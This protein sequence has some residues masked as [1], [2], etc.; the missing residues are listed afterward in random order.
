MEGINQCY[1]IKLILTLAV[2]GLLMSGCNT[3]NY[4][5]SND[6]KVLNIPKPFKIGYSVSINSIT[7]EKL[8]YAKSV[9]IDH[10]EL[11]GI[12][13][14]FNK[15][16]NFVDSDDEIEKKINKVKRV[17]DETDINVWSVHM[18]FS[19]Y[20]DLSTIWEEDR[21]MVV[22]KHKKLLLFLEI[23]EPE[24]ILFHPSYYLDPPN[25][26]N[27]R[28]SQLLKSAKELNKAV[29]RM[30]GTMVLENMLG[31][32]LMKGDRERPLMRTIEE[33]VEIFNHLPDSIFLAIDMNH[34]KSPERL[35]RAMGNRLKTVHIADGRGKAENHYFPCSGEG[36]NNWMEILTALYEV[37]YSGP[38][39]YESAYEDE[40]DMVTCYESLYT[41]FIAEEYPSVV[42]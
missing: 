10:I 20:M 15:N 9:G 42:K 28:K 2:S 16:G 41:K 26:R 11:S 33:T 3:R 18:A 8:N 19:Q 5:D 17:L 36:E 30:G 21:Q 12:N 27:T 40:I 31:P 38:F 25:Q 34:I 35:I 6:N 4:K 29:Q 24:F 14:F 39:M 37:G 13:S 32:K 23:L 7:P 1:T 22:A